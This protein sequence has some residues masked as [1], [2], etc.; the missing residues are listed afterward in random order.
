MTLIG[1]LWGDIRQRQTK[2]VRH[3]W[4]CLQIEPNL[5]S[6]VCHR[7]SVSQPSMDL[8]SNGLS[9]RSRTDPPTSRPSFSMGRSLHL[10]ALMDSSWS[11]V[12]RLPATVSDLKFVQP[13]R[14]PWMTR[15]SEQHWDQSQPVGL[16]RAGSRDRRSMGAI[17]WTWDQHTNLQHFG[18][19]VRLL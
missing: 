5:C 13:E 1:T 2:A 17:C 7:S 19:R 11:K 10:R 8:S 16:Q 14:L 3:N 15:S 9:G 18:S 12:L 6:F 4:P